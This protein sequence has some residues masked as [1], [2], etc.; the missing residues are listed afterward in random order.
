MDNGDK[1]FQDMV[2]AGL[3][4]ITPQGPPEMI[5]PLVVNPDIQPQN[6]NMRAV[7]AH[8]TNNTTQQT[9]EVDII[10]IWVDTPQG[11]SI[12]VNEAKDWQQIA[13]SILNT[14][15]SATSG[16]ITP[17]DDFKPFGG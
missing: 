5:Q 14:I 16:I 15:K 10:I 4:D 7:K 3:K 6:W 17:G 8:K 12:F 1:A 9:D 13:M 2:E 11:R